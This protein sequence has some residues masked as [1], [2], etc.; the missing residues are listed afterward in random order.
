M[1]SE[2]TYPCGIRRLSWFIAALLALPL[3][4][5]TALAQEDEEDEQI[6]EI[7]TVGSQIKGA[8]I[9]DALAVSVVTSQ[10]IEDLGVDSG[11]DLLEFMAEQGQ[12]FFTESE[13]I[14][15]GVNSARGDMGA[16]NLRNLG[17]GNTL[18]LLNGRRMVNAA[19][20]QTE[21]VGGSFIPVNTVNSQS[22]PVFGL[23]RVEVL[24]DGASAIYGADAVAGVV[25]YVMKDD[26]DGFSIQA[27]YADWEGLPRSDYKLTMEWGKNFN[28]G[29]TNLSIF[30]SYYDRDPV[31]SQDDPKWADDD[32]RRFLKET[33]PF[34]GD[35]SFRRSSVNSEYGQYD[36]IPS[37]S[38]LSDPFDFVDGSGEFNTYPVGD[39][40]CE[41]TD[42]QYPNVCF[43][44]DGNPIYRYNNNR[45]RDLYS[46]LK[47]THLFVFLNHEFNNGM[48]SFT[49]VSAYLSD[50]TTVRQASTRLS[51][52]ANYEIAADAY[53][54]PLGAVGTS[55][56]LPDSIIGPDIP[57]EGVPLRIDNYR[58]T[59]APRIVDND[60][61]TYRFLT[62]LRGEFGSNWDW[63]TALVWSRAEKEDVTKNRISNTL[64]Q[65]ALND[66]TPAGY[67]VFAGAMG[68]N[69]ERAL[70][71]VY[72]ENETELTLV[73]F[74]LSSGE[75]FDLWAGPVGFLAGVEYREES[76]VDDRDPRLDGTIQ[77]VDNAGNGFPI[78]SDVMNS[79]PTLDSE[80]SRDVFSAFT[81]FQV[82]LHARL[83]MQLAL[84]YE[85][86]SDIGD[87]TV[88]KIAMGW[89]PWDPFLV[90]GSWSE[91]YRVPNLVT[92]NES[93]VARSNTVDDRVCEYVS[94]FDPTGDVLDCSY[95]VQRAAGGSALLVPE[96]SENTS[97]G[98]VW[99]ITNNLTIT[100][101]WWSIEKD[102]T[103]GLF[104]EENHTALEL[105]GLIEAGTSNCPAAG[106]PS[107]GNPVV[108][109]ED[110]WDPASEEAALY[111]AAGI[112]N[113]G[114]AARVNDL[115]A[116]LDTRKLRGHDIGVYYQRET[117]IGDFNFRYV[118]SKLD[119]YEQLASGP[120]QRLLDAQEAGVLP[121]DVQVIGFANLIRQNGNPRWKHTARLR[122]NLGDWGA[123]L[124]GT[125]VSDAIETRPGLGDDGSPWILKPMSTYNL[126]VDYRFDTFGDVRSRLR[127]GIVNLT[128]ARAPLSS[129]RFGYFSDM[130]RDLPR[131]WYLDLRLDF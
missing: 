86:F 18:V 120:A 98:I 9:R 77:Y 88:G 109:R 14:S 79:S 105:L 47:R 93:G 80:G 76:F 128:D 89:R 11:D 125:K 70:I 41:F 57:V 107:I 116:N 68:T 83:D 59:D 121:P 5:G 17:T 29:R 84:R 26:F 72:R 15:G 39:P 115:Y 37:V 23:E 99:D 12:N 97:L 106:G 10:D 60:G 102:K 81:E 54:N 78:V 73:D 104:G 38:G 124:S 64:M 25:N 4:A 62:G 63:E 110:P 114:Q 100:L 36:V 127:L 129:Q 7:V 43:A 94:S 113:T 35:T 111:A 55:A 56:R 20:Y 32:F 49:E 19:S 130:H 108:I 51:A 96:E 44:A 112:C 1:L 61:E 52:V 45:N 53:W 30:G 92:V 119:E 21:L 50:T 28:G 58:W 67:N 40:N 16:Y 103:I 126:S 131:S 117:P 33:S 46:D 118:G 34:F 91:A 31:N 95:G 24:R 27:R 48:E 101:D 122:W 22:L 71:D 3:A 8:N 75:L 74:K 82:P 87:T 123:S 6:E 65:E 90:R 66:P 85:D 13:N 42:P 69:I 2:Y